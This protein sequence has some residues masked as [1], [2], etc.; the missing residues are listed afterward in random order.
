MQDKQDFFYGKSILEKTKVVEELE[1][2]EL[3]KMVFKATLNNMQPINLD[4]QNVNIEIKTQQAYE[5]GFLAGI[6]FI[7]L[8]LLVIHILRVI[9]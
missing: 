5:K 3:R 4:D 2:E 8:I 1:N 6:L 7:G 9:L